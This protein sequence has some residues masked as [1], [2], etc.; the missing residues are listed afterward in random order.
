M[1][2]NRYKLVFLT[3]FALSSSVCTT[4]EAKLNNKPIDNSKV[5]QE[6][7][8][9]TPVNVPD[10]YAEEIQEYL[11]ENVK[12]VTILDKI[13][14]EEENSINKNFP[15][16]YIDIQKKPTSAFIKFIG[17]GIIP[18]WER[19][20]F[21]IDVKLFKNNKEI[22][23]WSFHHKSVSWYGIWFLPFL[24]KYDPLGKVLVK[25][26]VHNVIDDIIKDNLL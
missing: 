13:D 6:L 11:E 8:I 1:S 18:S 19:N 10:I 16:L 7:V 14:K 20:E 26:T 4:F 23:N 25:N 15:K 12:K 22:A 24:T 21:N 5:I 9:E 2:F 17:L 3:L